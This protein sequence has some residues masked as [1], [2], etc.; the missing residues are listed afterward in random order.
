VPLLL[1]VSFGGCASTVPETSPLDLEVAIENLHRPLSGDPAALYRLRVSSS[2]GL[3]MSVVTSGDQGRLTVSEPFGAAVS[4]TAWSGSE[5]PIFFDLREGCRLEASDLEQALGV[6]AM[7]LPPAVRLL[8]GRLPA[9]DEDWVAARGD[10][11]ILVEGRQ[12]AALVRV[13]AD[14]WRVVSVEEAGIRGRGWRFELE[15]HSLSVPGFIRVENRD[16]RWAELELLRL[17]WN[18]DGELPPLP[19]LP[20]CTAVI[21]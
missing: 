1:A 17:E 6:A 4:L 7:P 12:W 8:V 3:R 19:D 15:D 13:A 2:G 14:P 16:G 5:P 10:G 18:R 20:P 11:R 21:D 9:V